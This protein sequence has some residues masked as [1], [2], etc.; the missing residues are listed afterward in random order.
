MSY[1]ACSFELMLLQ[2]A[3]SKRN[4]QLIVDLNRIVVLYS[5]ANTT[6]RD[7]LYKT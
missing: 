5:N 4:N 2:Y 3:D 1:L 6:R 7:I